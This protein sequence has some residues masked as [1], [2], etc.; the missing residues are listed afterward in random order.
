MGRISKKFFFSPRT[1]TKIRI[2]YHNRNYFV[3]SYTVGK[4]EKQ[5][6][7]QADKSIYTVTRIFM[8]VGRLNSIN[9]DSY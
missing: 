8:P 3:Y 4:Y 6:L 1:E 9:A 2:Q 5:D 7:E